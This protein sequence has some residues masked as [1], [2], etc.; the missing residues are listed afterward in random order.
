MRCFKETEAGSKGRPWE[1]RFVVQ[2]GEY[3]P[4]MEMDQI[5]NP[6]TDGKRKT[7]RH[8]GQGADR[9]KKKKIL[10]HKA[11]DILNFVPFGF[12]TLQLAGAAELPFTTGR[13]EHQELSEHTEVTMNIGTVYTSLFH[14]S[15]PVSPNWNPHWNPNSLPFSLCQH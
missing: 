13:E 11:S 15:A 3:S 7:L 9:V 4:W 14:S 5:W 8:V 10:F 2:E 6:L 12:A 1:V